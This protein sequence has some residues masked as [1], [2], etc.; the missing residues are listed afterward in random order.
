MLLTV[1]YFATLTC[2]ERSANHEEFG[3]Y[4]MIAKYMELLHQHVGEFKDQLVNVDKL[5]SKAQEDSKMFGRHMEFLDHGLENFRDQVKNFRGVVAH[6]AS[7]RLQMTRGILQEGKEQ[8]GFTHRLAMQPGIVGFYARRLLDEDGFSPGSHLVPLPPPVHPALD[9][10]LANL[11]G[12]VSGYLPEGSLPPIGLS[13]NPPPPPGLHPHGL[14]P[15]GLDGGP[16]LPM[17][18]GLDGGMPPLP[19][20]HGLGGGMPP[21]GLDGGL[22][23]PPHGHNGGL[24]LSPGLDGTPGFDGLGVGG[25]EEDFSS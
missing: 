14:H 11:H 7:N 8:G 4:P 5:S 3:H 12:Q 23:L 1:A 2:A 20:A 15:H 13:A 21:H 24:P 16:P 25:P 9:G 22:P 10:H 6:N 19:M 17:A 18:H